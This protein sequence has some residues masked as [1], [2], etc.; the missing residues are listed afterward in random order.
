MHRVTIAHPQSAIPAI[1]AAFPRIEGGGS[2]GD[3]YTVMARWINPSRGYGVTGG[4][5]YLMV[6]DVGAW[7]NTR[8]L[9]LPGQSADPRSSHYQDFYQ[10]WINGDMQPLLY[11]AAAVNA[12][13]A[14]RTVLEPKR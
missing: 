12:Q 6:V 10:P 8:M 2:G 4:A 14:E 13:A 9:N 11:S 5:S 7:D 1:A 3:A